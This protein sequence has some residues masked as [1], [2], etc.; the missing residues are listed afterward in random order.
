MLT[1]P[2]DLCC[3]WNNLDKQQF[4]MPCLSGPLLNHQRMYLDSLTLRQRIATY[5]LRQ[6]LSLVASASYLTSLL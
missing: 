1:T 5:M 2:S 3:R 6:R 4:I